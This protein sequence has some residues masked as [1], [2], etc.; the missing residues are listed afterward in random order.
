MRPSLGPLTAVSFFL[1]VACEGAAPAATLRE[2]PRPVPAVSKA[3]VALPASSLPSP[4]MVALGDP[5]TPRARPASEGPRSPIEI[6]VR[7]GESMGLYGRWAG[8][9]MR[10]LYERVGLRWNERLQVGRKLS[11]PLSETEKSRFESRRA[12]FAK[13]REAAFSSG[14]AR[15]YTVRRGDNPWRIARRLRVPLWLLEKLNP[16]R[17][18]SRLKIGEKIKVPESA[19]SEGNSG[20]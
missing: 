8:I 7:R 15:D 13:K 14:S 19:Q 6:E 3:E 10:D 4:V 2:A 18:L 9:P 5:G 12:E 17:Q 16:G 11:L 20:S 1:L